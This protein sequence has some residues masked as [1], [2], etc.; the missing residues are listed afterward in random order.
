MTSAVDIR[1]DGP[2]I[3][4][5]VLLPGCAPE[6]ALAAFTDPEILTTWWRGTLTAELV[7]GGDYIVDFA[8]IGAR[9]T[10]QILTFEPA[11]SL[12]FTWSWDGQPPDSTVLITAE[13]GREPRSALLT[14]RHGP[15]GNDEVGQ[16]AHQEHWEG[17]EFFL[18]RLVAALS[19][20]S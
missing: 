18:P 13:P 16:A 11:N 9:L 4:A 12:E 2:M 5:T 15:H 6:R 10:G 7:P 19:A 14:V 8:A 20:E 3:V 1:D 17:W